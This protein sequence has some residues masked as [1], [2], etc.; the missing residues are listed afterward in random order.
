MELFF[1]LISVNENMQSRNQVSKKGLPS[2]EDYFL[3]F[4]FFRLSSL[5]PLNQ[6]YS[7]IKKCIQQQ[8]AI[9]SICTNFFFYAIWILQSWLFCLQLLNLSSKLLQGSM[10]TFLTFL[11]K[12]ATPQRSWESPPVLFYMSPLKKH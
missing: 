1:T 5:A 10:S 11:Y 7:Y 2:E 3:I 8:T 6:K 9:S 12:N 4:W